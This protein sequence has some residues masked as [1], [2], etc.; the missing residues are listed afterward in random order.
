VV[1]ALGYLCFDVLVLYTA[2]NSFYVFLAFLLQAG[3][4]NSPFAAGLLI[5]PVAIAYVAASFVAG[6][7]GPRASGPVLVAGGVVLTIAYAG[8]ALTTWHAADLRGIELVPAR[9]AMAAAIRTSRPAVKPSAT[10]NSTAPLIAIGAADAA[11]SSTK[12]M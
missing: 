3:L 2:L 6:R 8:A 4:K 10:I 11:A 5:T 1:G 12:P 7:I 9:S